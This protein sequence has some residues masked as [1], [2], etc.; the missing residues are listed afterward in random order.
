MI[1]ISTEQAYIYATKNAILRA[2]SSAV[3][4]F[5]RSKIFD[6]VVSLTKKKNL[7]Y[8]HFPRPQ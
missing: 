8:L 1:K 6:E 3:R 5:S 2:V 7:A 4:M